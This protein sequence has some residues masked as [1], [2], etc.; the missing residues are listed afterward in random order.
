[1]RYKFYSDCVGWPE[2][3][4][5]PGGLSDMIDNCLV[6]SRPT[7]LKHIDRNELKEISSQ[8]GYSNHYKEGLTMSADWHISY[9][10]SNLHGER[11]YYFKHSAIEYVF[12]K[13]R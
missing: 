7:F 3:T 8:L 10:R 6:I 11:V 2:D 4:Q 9:Y 12:I 13:G 5:E 1:M